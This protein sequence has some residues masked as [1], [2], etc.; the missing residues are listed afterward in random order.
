M[1]FVSLSHI[2]NAPRSP[3]LLGVSECSRPS[4]ADQ[5][6]LQT[7]LSW[8]CNRFGSVFL[9]VFMALSRIIAINGY[10]LLYL[11][12]LPIL[13]FPRLIIHA[14]SFR[15]V[16]Y[17]SS[18]SMSMETR[19]LFSTGKC[20]TWCRVIM[21]PFDSWMGTSPVPAILHLCPLSSR[22]VP[23]ISIE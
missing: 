21:L 3:S 7:W 5:V 17:P 13:R 8:P 20:W 1:Y 9:P 2:E 11:C 19:L 16:L 12:L 18:A 4:L 10:K 22:T 23:L 15:V 6:W 14:D